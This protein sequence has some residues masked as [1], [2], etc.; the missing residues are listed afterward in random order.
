M[1]IC[2]R[3]S[4]SIPDGARFCPACGDPVTAGDRARS[5]DVP[6]SESVSLVCPHC[7]QQALYTIPFH[8]VGEVICP[9]CA[10]L[11]DTTIVRVRSKR[12]TG[13]KQLNRRSF[14]VRAETLDGQEILVEFVRPWNEDFELRSRD[15]AAFSYV[16]G[17]LW[18]VQNLSVERSMKL[19]SQ[20]VAA[21]GSGCAVLILS[22]IGAAGVFAF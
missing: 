4:T 22:L 1:L 19:V 2:N 7:E 15:L 12:S 20:V 8:G 3:C 21:R 14:S 10:G 6:S 5:Q 9:L 13:Q 16:Q 17:R 11:F 18:I